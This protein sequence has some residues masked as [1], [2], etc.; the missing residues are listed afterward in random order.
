MNFKELSEKI[1]TTHDLSKV[2]AERIV[3]DVFETIENEIS[4]GGEVSVH[5]FGRF[6][7][8]KAAARNG[9]N[10]RTGEMI[11]IPAKSVPKFVAHTA[12]K[13]AVIGL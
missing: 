7:I 8:R 1:A 9:R 3:K 6:T 11:D 13:E 10:L 2:L 5:G 12:L 4:T